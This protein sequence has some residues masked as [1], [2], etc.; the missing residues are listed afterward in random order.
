MPL[1]QHDEREHDPTE[2]VEEVGVEFLSGKDTE[3]A[4]RGGIFL[5]RGKRPSWKCGDVG[6]GSG[7]DPVA[8]D[9][10]GEDGEKGFGDVL[11]PADGD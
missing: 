10:A 6:I 5:R 7:A 4:H 1:H 2:G 9:P 8:V 11:R 3:N